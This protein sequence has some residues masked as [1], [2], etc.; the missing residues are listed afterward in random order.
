[1]QAP[2]KASPLSILHHALVSIRVN[3]STSGEPKGS[4]YIRTRREIMPHPDVK[5]N[6]LVD[7][8][9]E[10][11][12]PEN[13]E[14]APYSGE[15]VVRGWFV[16]AEKYPEE[17]HKELIEVTAASILYGT[18]RE[19]LANFTARSLHGILSIPSVTFDPISD[20]SKIAP[21]EPIKPAARMSKKV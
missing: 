6:W 17:K 19:A 10:F 9:V 14:E 3:A 5:R 7:L 2:L 20:E 12:T 1:M 18:C 4:H 21:K 13:R 8:I 15:I 16:I 11:G